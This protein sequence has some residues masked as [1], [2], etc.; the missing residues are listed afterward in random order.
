MQFKKI[1]ADFGS[2]LDLKFIQIWSFGP[3]FGLN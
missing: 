1:L 2:V 3:V